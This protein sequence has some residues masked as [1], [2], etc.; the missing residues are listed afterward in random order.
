MDGGQTLRVSAYH[1]HQVLQTSEL[2]T[3]LRQTQ[4]RFYALDTRHVGNDFTV[5]DGFNIL[6][7]RVKEAE[8]DNALSYIASTYDPYDNVIRDGLYDGGRKVISFAGVLQQ[9]VFPLPELLQMSMKYGAESM[10]RP[11]EIEIAGILNEHR[12]GQF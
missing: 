11:V 7:L 12:T 2:E 1:P 4:T 8:R 5:D 6:N 10:R 3:A 9:D